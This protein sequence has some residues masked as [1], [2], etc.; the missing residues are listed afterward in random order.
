M[1]GTR[2]DLIEKLAE[3]EHDQW[4]SWSKHIAKTW[5]LDT[6]TKERWEASWVPYNQLSEEMK[7][8]D[9]VWAVK[10]LELVEDSYMSLMS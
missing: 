8:K 3:L 10:S 1:I 4:V 7:A 9:R 6:D 5:F 2:K